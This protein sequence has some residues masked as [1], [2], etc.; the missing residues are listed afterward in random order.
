MEAYSL[1]CISCYTNGRDNIFNN[2][3]KESKNPQAI[4]NGGSGTNVGNALRWMGKMGKQFAPEL[5]KV[6]G[7]VTGIESL[8]KLGDAIRTDGQLSDLDKELLLKEL[9]LDMVEMEEATKRLQSDNQHMITRLVRPVSFVLMLMLFIS[10][11][12]FDGNVG[13]FK[14]NNA[15]IEVIESL[16]S[17]MVIFYFSS[18][19]LEKISK[20]IKKD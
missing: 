9:Q 14:V 10:I 8:N 2:M 7:T 4:K 19:G 18:R 1:P 17:I 5:L 6:A 20:I 11:V 15:Y 13:D 3:S 16:F 12:M